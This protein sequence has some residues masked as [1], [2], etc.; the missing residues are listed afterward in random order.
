MQA[1]PERMLEGRVSYIDPQLNVETRT[2]RVRIE[3]PNARGDLRFGM[4]A[5]AVFT[6][7]DDRTVATIHRSAVQ[8]VGDRTVVYLASSRDSGVFIERE[9]HLGPAVGDL[10]TVTAG[11][12][13][14][15]AVVTTGSFAI[16]AERERLGLRTRGGV[17]PNPG[18]A[19]AG[20]ATTSARPSEVQEARITVS[21]TSFAPSRLVLQAGIPARL[22]FERI[23]DKTCATSVVFASLK[24]RK[25]LPLR[26][27]VIV[28]FTPASPGEIAFACGMN[29]LQGTVVVR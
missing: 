11:V 17:S 18:G 19:D 15:D 9:V 22:T 3:L 10:V 4:L 29:M 23:S 16:R 27:P 26:E 13:S 5:E 2:G 25:D 14:G 1:F 7:A 21:D 8:N 12:T 24:I 6:D 20:T 28:E